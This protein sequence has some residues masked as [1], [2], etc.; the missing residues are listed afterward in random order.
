MDSIPVIKHKEYKCKLCDKVY[1]TRQN[2]WKHNSKHHVIIPANI[3]SRPTETPPTPADNKHI[4]NYC[5][6]TFSRQDCLK[7]HVDKRCKNKDKKENE[8]KMIEMQKEMDNIKKE[9]SLL[10]NNTSK[11]NNKFSKSNVNNGVINN[12]IHINA[13]GN[14]PMNLSIDEIKSIFDKQV[15]SLIK[16][17]QLLNFDEKRKNNHSFCI[18]IRKCKTF[19]YKSGFQIKSLLCKF[20]FR[21]YH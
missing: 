11:V 15:F 9:L 16:Y 10:K 3:A 2:L 8:N 4:C 1:S 14:E 13:V 12:N 17:L 7:R 20:L 19:S 21:T 18:F 6:K 5:N